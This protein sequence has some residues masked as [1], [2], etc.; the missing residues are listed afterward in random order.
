M[1]RIIIVVLVIALVIVGVVKFGGRAA[2][3]GRR[4]AQNTGRPALRYD[5]SAVTGRSLLDRFQGRTLRQSQGAGRQGVF[6]GPPTIDV[7]QQI[8]SVERAIAQR[9]A[10]SSWSPWPTP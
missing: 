5:F 4:R 8:D 1:E 10:A 6:T 7:N 9:V 2:R 3:H